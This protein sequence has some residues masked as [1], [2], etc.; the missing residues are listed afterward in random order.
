[1]ESHHKELKPS[2]P[3]Q[4][5]RKIRSLENSVYRLEAWRYRLVIGV[6]LIIIAMLSM[7]AMHYGIKF[8]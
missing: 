1:M 7:C 2:T 6:E 3:W 8:T 4:I 5:R